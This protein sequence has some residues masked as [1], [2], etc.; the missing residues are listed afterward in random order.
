MIQPPN[1]DRYSFGDFVLLPGTRELLRE[2]SAVPLTPKE[3]QTLL[4][5]VEAQGTALTREHMIQAIWPNTVRGRYKSR[6]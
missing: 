6:P 1:A 3:F 2:G 4:L 5:L